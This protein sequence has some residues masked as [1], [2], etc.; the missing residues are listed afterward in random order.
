[1]NEKR[2]A[3]ASPATAP[4]TF[5]ATTRSTVHPAGLP[6]SSSLR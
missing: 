2:N 1:M 3:A 6:A 4:M 5:S